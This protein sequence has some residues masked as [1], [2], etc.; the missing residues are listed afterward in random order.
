MLVNTRKPFVPLLLLLL[1]ISATAAA[2]EI[3]TLK[4]CLDTALLHNRN[5]QINRNVI[6][7]SQEKEQEIRAGRN[8]KVNASADYKYFID[9]PYQL[10]PATALNPQATPGQ[11]KEL[12]F[13]VPHNINASVQVAMPLYQPQLNGAIQNAA[14]ARELSGLQYRR[15]EEQVMVDVTNLY[16]NAQILRNQLG[17]LERN[18]DNTRQLLK[19]MQLLQEQLMARGTDVNK[20]KLQAEQLVTRQ[21]LVKNQYESVLNRLRLNMGVDPER[22]MSVVEQIRIQAAGDYPVHPTLE[23][24]LVK[25]QQKLLNNE[26]KT[27]QQSGYLPSLN[28]VGAYGAMGFGYDKSPNSFLKFFRTGFAGLQISYPIFNGT[29]TKRKLSQKQLELK[30]NEL[31]AAFISDKNKV[32]IV[33]WEKQRTTA[34]KAVDNTVRQMQLAATIYAQTLLQQ[35][36]GTASLTD[37]LLSDNALRE[38]QQ[39]YLA[40]VVDYLKAD[41]ALKQLTGNF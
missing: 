37:V 22:N 36:E 26:L 3:W 5:L 35:K 25:T 14:I 39:N 12:Q 33:N 38:S 7:Q 16:Y 1:L 41:V 4:Q 8:P 40:A 19:N 2:Q 18:L 24:Q 20:V 17:F 34:L 6:L 28:L 31:Q 9:L 10:M 29:V 30:N 13:G 23:F 11:F 32:E 15:S 27:I 21:E